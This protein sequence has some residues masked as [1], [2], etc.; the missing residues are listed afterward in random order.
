VKVN[1]NVHEIVEWLI[2]TSC[3]V[4][5]PLSS[6]TFKQHTHNKGQRCTVNALVKLG[7]RIMFN[8]V[9]QGQSVTNNYAVV[10]IGFQDFHQ[11]LFQQ[12]L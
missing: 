5:L 2:S 7:G 11:R 12:N 3:N 8:T 1:K 9:N 6:K 10:Q 4:K